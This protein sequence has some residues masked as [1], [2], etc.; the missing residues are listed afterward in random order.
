MYEKGYY[1][2][3][4]RK[5][6]LLKRDDLKTRLSFAKWKENL[7]H[8]ASNKMKEQNIT[9]ESLEQFKQ[10][11]VNTMYSIRIETINNLIESMNAQLND[12]IRN[13]GNRTRY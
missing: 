5:K 6:G 10:R 13:K 9:K 1:Y 8:I 3:Q 7:F 4:A 11:A 12:V 2:L